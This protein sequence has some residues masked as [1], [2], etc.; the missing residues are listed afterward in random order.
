M[1]YLETTKEN[2][3][4]FVARYSN[5]LRC[6]FKSA[7]YLRLHRLI[8][9]FSSKS[10]WE[11]L[12]NGQDIESI[13]YAVPD[14]FFVWVKLK[15]EEM[16]KQHGEIKTKAEMACKDVEYIPTQKEKALVVLDKY[17]SISGLVFSLLKGHSIDNQIWEM[18]EPKF[19][20]PFKNN[21]KE[22]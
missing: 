1:K 6:K 10:I 22:L 16:I 14:E 13:L 4:G 8:T 12:M 11:C 5:G 17:K 2:E 19:E 9:G 7:E 20:L 18:I 15:K 21:K 3:E